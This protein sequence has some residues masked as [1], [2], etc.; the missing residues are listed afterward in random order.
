LK[1]LESSIDPKAFTVDRGFPKMVC[2][3]CF[4]DRA[5]KQNQVSSRVAIVE[6]QSRVSMRRYLAQSADSNC[7]C[8]G[9]SMWVRCAAGWQLQEAFALF[10]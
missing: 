7:Y 2:W 4:I 5:S 9:G 3:L 8:C 1:A 6:W 10:S